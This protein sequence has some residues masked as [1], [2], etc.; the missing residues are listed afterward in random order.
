MVVAEVEA[1]VGEGRVVPGFAGEGGEAGDLLMGFGGGFGQGEIA[2]FA[3]DD[4]VALREEE[5]AVAVV[6]AAPFFF[7]G[8]GVNA[9]EVC[10]VVRVAIIE[11]VK[12]AFV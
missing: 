2:V 7:A 4:E 12:V 3:L 9:D 6:F 8:L 5:L 1:A 10:G 11:P